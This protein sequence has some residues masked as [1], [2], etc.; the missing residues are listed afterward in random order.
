MKLLRFLLAL[1]FAACGIVFAALNSEPISLD[2]Y[3]W[4]FRLSAGLA[5]L[6][7]VF[8]GA[9][10]GGIA[11][12]VGSVMPNRRRIEQAAADARAEAASEPERM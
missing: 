8:L 5:V 3:F 11:V 1:A 6:M 9:L 7:A 10:V 12:S 2:F 4:Q